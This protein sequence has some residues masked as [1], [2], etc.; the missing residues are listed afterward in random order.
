MN[1]DAWRYRLHSVSRSL[2][3]VLFN[4]NGSVFASLTVMGTVLVLVVVVVVV[5]N[6][7]VLVL[8]GM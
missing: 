4:A 1:L 8:C 7:V 3:C 2:L 5:A 6:V